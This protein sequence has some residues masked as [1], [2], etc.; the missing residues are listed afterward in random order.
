MVCDVAFVFWQFE[1]D[2]LSFQYIFLIMIFKFP[3][4]IGGPYICGQFD[5]N[6]YIVILLFTQFNRLNLRV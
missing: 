4:Y 3:I 1:Y 2:I 5:C 6:Y